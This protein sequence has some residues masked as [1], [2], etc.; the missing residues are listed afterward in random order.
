[1]INEKF[2]SHWLK[3]NVQQVSKKTAEKLFDKGMTIYLHP[4]NMRFDSLIWQMPYGVK[5][6]ENWC[7]NFEALCNDFRYYNCD[8]ERGR[9]IHYFVEMP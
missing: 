5:K 6:P 7:G 4:S 3:S 1:M 8:S 9:Y 2:Y